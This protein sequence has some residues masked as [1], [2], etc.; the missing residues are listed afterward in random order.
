PAVAERMREEVLLLELG[1]VP[2]GAHADAVELSRQALEAE[3]REE[4]SRRGV[5]LLADAVEPV[6][7]QD[8][9]P[10]R[11]TKRDRRGTSGGPG[12]DDRDAHHVGNSLSVSTL[13]SGGKAGSPGPGCSVTT[14][15]RYQLLTMF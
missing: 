1:R 2:R 5:E 3:P 11:L 6:A 9:L 4:W 10:A 12:A 8:D 13:K 15:S 14:P 7:E